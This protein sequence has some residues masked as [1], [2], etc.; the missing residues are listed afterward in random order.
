MSLRQGFGA[1]S[2]LKILVVDDDMYQLMLTIRELHLAGYRNTI[3]AFGVKEAV[4]KALLERPDLLI[5]DVKLG[6]ARRGTE[7]IEGIHSAT[8]S[9]R[10]VIMFVSMGMPA[11]KDYMYADKAYFGPNVSRLLNLAM[12]GQTPHFYGPQGALV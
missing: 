5:L 6:G 2:T 3:E 11:P 4:E 1:N 12:E 10:P 8:L 7:V 9:Y